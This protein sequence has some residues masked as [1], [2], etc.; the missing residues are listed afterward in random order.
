MSFET[1]LPLNTTLSSPRIHHMPMHRINDFQNTFPNHP[2]H[3]NSYLPRPQI[4]TSNMSGIKEYPPSP[5][6]SLAPEE[7]A[8]ID[9][10]LSL[11]NLII[12]P[13]KG[14]QPKKPPVDLC[15]QPLSPKHFF[16]S[17][18]LPPLPQMLPSRFPAMSGGFK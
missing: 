18:T 12:F 9:G 15:N 13:P 5:S 6:R 14:E 11:A 17:R 1:P 10:L 16:G 4:L 3:Q 2:N 8:G 7:S